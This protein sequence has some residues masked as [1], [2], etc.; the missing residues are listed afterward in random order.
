MQNELNCLHSCV[1][2]IC[3]ERKK[4]F[5]SALLTFV[6]KA[7]LFY[8]VWHN[9]VIHSKSLR[10]FGSGRMKDFTEISEIIIIKINIL[11]YQISACVKWNRS[12]YDEGCLLLRK[13]F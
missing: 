6:R 4:G 3:I 11:L 9:S 7:G 8:R 10:A 12:V 1:I 2:I 13:L 5:L